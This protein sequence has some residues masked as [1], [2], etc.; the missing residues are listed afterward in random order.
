M[1][2]HLN[3]M[4]EVPSNLIL[5][6]TCAN[7]RRASRALTQ[8]YDEALRPSGLRSTQFTILQALSLT[9]E[10]LQGQLSSL[11]VIDSTTLTR[12]LEIMERDGWIAKRSGRDKRE[13][14][15]RLTK[16]GQAQFC[17][18]LPHWERVQ[19]RFR[20]KLGPGRWDDLLQI[21]SEV[22][23]AVTQ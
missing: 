11:L 17:R 2:M 16:A 15:L 23:N 1:Y 20:A 6:C 3:A 4:K 5:P 21:T 14:W 8:L 18:A 7:L 22:T 12:T 13:R 10:I 19:S 9:G